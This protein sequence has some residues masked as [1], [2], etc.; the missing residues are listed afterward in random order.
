MTVMTPEWEKIMKEE[1][2]RRR[3]IIR[4]KLGFQKGRGIR[5]L[6]K[7]AYE[8][9]NGKGYY[10]YTIIEPSME[11]RKTGLIPY[12]LCSVYNYSCRK[13]IG[14]ECLGLMA[15]EFPQLYID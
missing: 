10:V 13:A 3:Q 12:V 9:P 8:L 15:D 4:D 6:Y 14:D 1:D 2:L 11:G 7:G 5:L